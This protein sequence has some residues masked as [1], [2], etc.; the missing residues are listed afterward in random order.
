MRQ[1]IRLRCIQSLTYPCRSLQALTEYKS[2]HLSF[3]DTF[4]IEETDKL[5]YAGVFDGEGTHLKC[6]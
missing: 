6:T 3:Q 5:L 2:E 1:M 4:I